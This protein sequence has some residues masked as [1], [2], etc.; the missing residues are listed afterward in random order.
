MEVRI[1]ETALDILGERAQVTAAPGIPAVGRRVHAKYWY[2]RA[3]GIYAGT[4]E[5]QKNIISERL[6]G[7]PKEPRCS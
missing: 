5:I 1:Y 6:L 7:L 4:T 2:A 3:S